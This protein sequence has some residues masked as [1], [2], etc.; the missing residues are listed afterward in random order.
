MI[1]RWAGMIHICRTIKETLRR[2]RKS[3]SGHSVHSVQHSGQPENP[4]LYGKMRDMSLILSLLILAA[5]CLPGVS[6]AANPGLTGSSIR[7]LVVDPATPS[8]L[9]AGLAGGNVAKSVD[10]GATWTLTKITFSTSS[11]TEIAI[12]P[13]APSIIYASGF[14]RGAFVDKSTD[15]GTTWR[16]SVDPGNGGTFGQGFGALGVPV[17][18]ID[19]NATST[20]YAG[21]RATSTSGEIYKS[22]NGGFDWTLSLTGVSLLRDMAISSTGA[23]YAAARFSGVRKSVNGGGSWTVMNNGI[24][25][26][27]AE[28]LVID[29]VTP[30][31]V[32]LGTANGGIFKSMDAGAS[33]MAINSGL[34]TSFIN[35]LVIDPSNPSILYAANSVLSGSQTGG[36]FK[37]VNAGASWTPINNGLALRKP[38][39]LAID[40]QNP[41][42]VYAGTDSG[43]YRSDDGGLTWVTPPPPFTSPPPGPM[44][45]G[46]A[47]HRQQGTAQDPVG[48]FT[49]ELFNQSPPDINLG[50]PMPLVFQRY[51]A[52]FLRRSLIVGDLGNDWQHN[53]DARLS[54]FGNTAK[55]VSWKGRVTDFVKNL[56]T[57]VWEQQTNLDTTYKLTI[58]AGQN[59]ALFDPQDN[60]IYAF[61][62]VTGKLVIVADG[63]GNVHTVTYNAAGQIQSVSD[64]LGRTLT[65]TY[66][67]AA[68]P[69]IASVSDGTRSIIFQY[70]DPLD[71]ENMTI[72]TD[73]RGGITTYAYKDTTGTAD[74]ALMMQWTLPRLNVPFTQIFD[75]QGRVATQT[76]ANGNAFNF[77]YVPPDTVITDPLGNIRGH[78]HTATGELSISQDQAGQQVQIGS[79]A[80][81]RRN[82]ITDRLGDVTTM[83]YHA[84]SGKLASRANADGTTTSFTY[85]PRVAGGVTLHDMSGVTN[86]DGTTISLIHDAFG[87]VTGSTDQLGNTSSFT[88]NGLGQ[89]L[90]ATNKLLGVTT[91]TY[92]ADGTLATTMDPAANTTSF[93]YDLLRRP[94]LITH[95]DGSTRSLTYDPANRP[96]TTTNENGN[97]T[98]LTYDANGNLATITDPLTNTTAFAYDGNDRLLSAT[99][100]LGGISSQTFDPLNRIAST[101][102]ANGNVTTN[103]Y[104]IRNR[105]TSITD[106]LGN[107]S[108]RTYDA[109]GIITSRANPLGNTTSFVSDKMGRIT[110]ATSP[111][112]NINRV[113]YD[114]MGRVVTA[115]DALNQVTTFS[116]DA[117]GLISGIALPGG[118][119]STTVTR[120][121]SGEPISITDPNG[122]VRIRSYDT[123]GR[124][125]SATDPLGQTRT[126]T[127]NN[128]NR[129]WVTIYPGSLGGRILTYD[130]VGN[131]AG[132]EYRDG[133]NMTTLTLGFTYDADN[134]LTASNNGGVTPNNMTRAYDANG[135]ISNSNGIAIT[136]D[137]GGRIT[138]MALATGK[139]VTYAYDANNHVTSVADWA[140]GVT[141]FTYDNA[142]RLTGITRPNGINTVNTWDNSSRL[143][144]ISEGTV[145]SISLTRDARG[146]ITAATR[147]V[148]TVATASGVT[149]STNTFDAASQVSGNTYDVLGRQT[150]AGVD[151]FTWDAASRLTG[152]T[153]GGTTAVNVYDSLGYRTR[154]TVGATTSDFVWNGAL[155]LA[156]I[157]VERRGGADF[158]YFIHTPGG[159]L[160]YS[161][162][163]ATNA[164]SFYHYDE[165]GNTIFVTN[166]A[167]TTIGSYA[168]TPF[169]QL[170]AATGGLDNPFTWQGQNGVMDEG[171]GL[172]YVRARFYDANTGRFISRD[173]RKSIAP[174][175][176]NPYQYALNNPLRFVDVNGLDPDDADG[177][178]LSDFARKNDGSARRD[179]EEV[180]TFSSGGRGSNN[181]P[182]DT[183]NLDEF[184][185]VPGQPGVVRKRK[186]DGA[187]GTI[188]VTS[189]PFGFGSKNSPFSFTSESS[190]STDN[191]SDGPSIKFLPESHRDAA[192]EPSGSQPGGSK[193]T[194]NDQSSNDVRSRDLLMWGGQSNPKG[195]GVK[196]DGNPDL[197]AKKRYELPMFHSRSPQSALDKAA[198][199]LFGED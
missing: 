15:A 110:Q 4:S 190:T 135:R 105:L 186:N 21:T 193:K 42:R 112:G 3:G 156:S 188:F 133:G 181:T 93:G 177:L 123:S 162:N 14:S 101:T 95:A 170:M 197:T 85:T 83:S 44:S 143:T 57:G 81:G 28:V 53:F 61:D 22:V 37:S 43:V 165:M 180:V 17:L 18:A 66:N 90:T 154:R 94:I 39:E 31:T 1:E 86:A 104:D 139:A 56:A 115:T 174:R 155:G 184:E 77:A 129:P 150:A 59:A 198:S 65:F 140:G 128:R 89:V 118:A 25:N 55:Y 169:G 34:T 2:Q 80:T 30:S 160:L 58:P 157:S 87:N 75:A 33:W 11:V 192:A 10:G 5:F 50:G 120:N 119:I 69:K 23:I 113:S 141:S 82:A 88:Y 46:S 76:N 99:D 84:P 153:V 182:Q 97:T 109:E 68:T 191:L 179:D 20:I 196:E 172:Y 63:K 145:S 36:I 9:Y 67:A 114:S 195:L 52:A 171:N 131:L 7:K 106:A 108:T 136:R 73:V 134:R 102:D 124:L 54:V 16:H 41:L 78:R 122:N 49:G 178:K 72:V 8:T 32:Y 168:Y 24:T 70:T 116:R 121:A 158:R 127:Y 149:N 167:G 107:V 194:S 71:T 103:G 152:Y 142:G 138:S 166:D 176:V 163:A 144:G 48:T 159:A 137:P 38:Q 29:P 47:N 132:S 19:P 60:R 35:S 6:T 26:K 161:I 98:T 74:K 12:N 130:P 164:R 79:D 183:T 147:T 146:Q 126:T 117:R 64:G 111:L 92:N 199:I 40:L 185:A 148:P 13:A 175:R 27:S 45:G 125:T 187:D 91:N 62:A 51:Y 100:P 151:T 96:L 173:V 189:D